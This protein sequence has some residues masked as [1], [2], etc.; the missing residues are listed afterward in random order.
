MLYC[1]EER[2][3]I[4]ALIEASPNGWIE[5]GR[6]ALSPLT[7]IRSPKGAV[8]THPVITN[9]K[10]YLRDQNYIYCHDVKKIAP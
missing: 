10:L 4:V 6:F 8:W 9:G 3:G 7:N 1:L 5:K 2:T